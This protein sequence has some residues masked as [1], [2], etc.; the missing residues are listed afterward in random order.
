MDRREGEVR[1]HDNRGNRDRRSDQSRKRRRD[2]GERR[3]ERRE[4]RRD[5]RS[6]ERRDERSYERRAGRGDKEL[7]VQQLNALRDI[8]TSLNFQNR[9]LQ[10]VALSLGVPEGN[11]QFGYRGNMTEPRTNNG[12]SSSRRNEDRNEDD[13]ED[14]NEM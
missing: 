6:Y 9:L 11:V 5:E 2:D 12:E 1:S 4:E 13:N 3:D 8:R 7:A 10:Q 14:G